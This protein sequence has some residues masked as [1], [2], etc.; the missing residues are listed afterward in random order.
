MKSIKEKSI[1]ELEIQKSKF[2]TVLYPIHNIEEVKE[3]LLLCIH[4]RSKRKM[5]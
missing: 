2:I 5:Q 4:S 3:A 1:S